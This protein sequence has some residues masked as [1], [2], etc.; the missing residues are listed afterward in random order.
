MWPASTGLP[1]CFQSLCQA[2]HR[3]SLWPVSDLPDSCIPISSGLIQA[4]K[5][6]GSSRSI[7]WPSAILSTCSCNRR[8]VWKE[9]TQS[10]RSNKQNTGLSSCYLK[11]FFQVPWST[12]DGQVEDKPITPQSNHS[13]F[14]PTHQCTNSREHLSEE[15]QA[16]GLSFRSWVLV[17][18][19]SASAPAHSTSWCSMQLYS[20]PIMRKPH[21]PKTA[22]KVMLST[23]TLFPQ[24]LMY[25]L[26]LWPL[27]LSLNKG[28]TEKFWN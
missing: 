16:L 20:E 1:C 8:W 15:S 19:I 2:L 4:D 14:L 18:L 27:Y 22:F 25:N 7:L 12:G 11:P 23:V 10:Y 5:F 13:L 17:L 21:S 6:T 9:N 3:P 28:L 24:E 26:R